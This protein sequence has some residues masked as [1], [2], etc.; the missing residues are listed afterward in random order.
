ML[1]WLRRAFD[2]AD[3]ARSELASRF[4]G[5]DGDGD[6]GTAP[7]PRTD[8]T[9]REVFP[10]LR[11]KRLPADR[12]RL[13]RLLPWLRP[14]LLEATLRDEEAEADEGA[15]ETPE[16]PS[17]I[18]GRPLVLTP[19]L[20]RLLAEQDRARREFTTDAFVEFARTPL[21]AGIAPPTVAVAPPWTQGE[22][23]PSKEDASS[24]GGGQGKG[25]PT[26]PA[27]AGGEAGLVLPEP[28]TE[29]RTGVCHWEFSVMAE[30]SSR[31]ADVTDR[32]V[33]HGTAAELLRD[34]QRLQIGWLRQPGDA[35]A[36]PET[37][38]KGCWDYGSLDAE[39][40]SYWKLASDGVAGDALG[41][42]CVPGADPGGAS[43]WEDPAPPGCSDSPLACPA[44]GYVGPPC[45]VP[46]HVPAVMT[47]VLHDLAD[48]AAPGGQVPLPVLLGRSDRC[49][50][51]EGTKECDP[52]VPRYF[53]WPFVDSDGTMQSGELASR[54][55]LHSADDRV[56]DVGSNEDV[57]LQEFM[58]QL[59]LEDPVLGQVRW[60]TGRSLPYLQLGNELVGTT[61]APE[62]AWLILRLCELAHRCAPDL[63]RIFPGLAS[64]SNRAAP[65]DPE[66]Y[67]TGTSAALDEVFY[68]LVRAATLV[69]VGT[70]DPT[71]FEDVL[72][73][74]GLAWT[75]DTDSL[76]SALNG[77]EPSP[78]YSVLTHSPADVF[79]LDFAAMVG[80][81]VAAMK[82]WCAA[83]LAAPFHVMDFHWYNS[84]GHP[85]GFFYLHALRPLARALRLALGAWWNGGAAIP[86]WCTET[87]ISSDRN[88]EHVGG[89]AV[90]V[91]AGGE[92][93]SC[94]AH[95]GRCTQYT[96][97]PVE[98]DDPMGAQAADLEFRSDPAAVA[99]AVA[100]HGP[101][102]PT[103]AVEH[104]PAWVFTSEFEQAVQMWSRLCF[105]AAN[106]VEKA[107]WYS[108]VVAETMSDGSATEFYTYG[109]TDDLMVSTFD[110]AVGCESCALTDPFTD[111]ATPY[112]MRSKKRAF[113][114][115]KRW[116]QYLGRYLCA[117]VLLRFDG[118]DA[119]HANANQGF[120]AVVFRIGADTDA[121]PFALVTWTD[122][123]VFSACAEAA[124]A[125]PLGDCV[126]RRPVIFVPADPAGVVP[127]VVQ[128]IPS[129]EEV[130]PAVYDPTGGTP[131]AWT[132]V[133]DPCLADLEELAEP[134]AGSPG[135]AGAKV[136]RF[137]P[138]RDLAYTPAPGILPEILGTRVGVH[139]FHPPVLTLLPAGELF[140][141]DEAEGAVE[142]LRELGSA[143]L[144]PPGCG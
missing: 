82:A 102:F 2:E 66:H 11:P 10:P 112:R 119:D 133:D 37:M 13:A 65:G 132:E 117:D 45:E 41:W 142:S 39:P 125:E 108:N 72:P 35:D 48:T 79:P 140:L 9:D 121:H 40:A 111:A 90:E 135:Y 4:V 17:R 61:G 15:G 127:R 78:G 22:D 103:V 93:W 63:V 113:C 68:H 128:T 55:N 131:G 8:G 60:G 77:V 30:G 137:G 85:G 70:G 83:H 1:P 122:P 57:L 44:A 99:A 64:P 114:A 23:A 81:H 126:P 104:W 116:N 87:G 98:P 74:I 53:D 118:L 67:L 138:D 80:G 91:E 76:L 28:W 88:P 84:R 46:T 52:A 38:W 139:A 100:G 19:A 7:D 144:N 110:V 86:L 89:A 49:E 124:A 62:L 42:P 106:R 43:T 36:H 5:V 32:R 16:A 3:E 96:V 95:L 71:R 109:L 6:G 143:V 92:H 129:E 29:A 12:E 123:Q 31:S 34:A 47:D 107:W 51:I 50:L 69:R 134:E 75:D 120:Y 20:G 105:L 14:M 115:L 24:N 59:L 26:L 97:G 58:R 94:F 101:G 56:A 54:F 25:E 141:Y 27:G 136:W 73:G 21:A 130:D 33:V 18:L